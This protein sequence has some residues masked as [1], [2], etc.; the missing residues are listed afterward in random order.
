MKVEELS[1]KQEIDQWLVEL[2]LALTLSRDAVAKAREL[3]ASLSETPPVDPFL[4]D[5]FDA[6]IGTAEERAG[7]KLWPGEWVNANP[8]LNS[9]WFGNPPRQAVHTGA[10]LNLNSPRWNLDDGAPVFAAANGVVTFAQIVPRGTWG[11]LVVIRHTLP[12]GKVVHTRYGHMSTLAVTAGQEVLRGQQ[13]GTIGGTEYG[14][15]DHLHMDISLSGILERDPRH[16]PGANLASVQEHYVA[17]RAF[18]AAH[19]PRRT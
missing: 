16:W 19:R 4:Y 11:G 17:P 6:P 3:V 14:V 7:D 10:D 13:I 15:A 9:Y 18:L 2:D 1:T 8:F 12:D 5:G